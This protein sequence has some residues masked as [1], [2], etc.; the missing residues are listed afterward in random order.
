MPGNLLIRKSWRRMST[1][2]TRMRMMILIVI[3]MIIVIMMMSTMMIIFAEKNVTLK[4][5]QTARDRLAG[6]AQLG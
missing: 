5:T 4:E 1:M 2:M 6:N 3:M